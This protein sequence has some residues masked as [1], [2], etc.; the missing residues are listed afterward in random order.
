MVLNSVDFRKSCEIMLLLV[1]SCWI[2]GFHMKSA[3][4]HKFPMTQA[5]HAL[6]ESE[7]FF[8]II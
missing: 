4:F 5:P 1:N 8:S 3:R 6:Y 7:V 2:G